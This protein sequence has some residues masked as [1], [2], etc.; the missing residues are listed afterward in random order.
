V[1]GSLARFIILPTEEDYPDENRTGGLRQAPPA[2]IEGLQRLAEGG[3]G[4]SGDIADQ[5]ARA[6]TAVN[7]MTVPMDDAAQARF[8]A[9]G[10]EITIELRAA[11]GTPHTPILARIKENA[12]KVALIVAVG[13]DATQPVIRLDD[14]VWAIDFVRHFARRTIDA[15]ERNVADTQIEAHLKRVRE[16]IRQAGS[17]GISRSQLPRATQWLKVRDREEILFTL[18]ESGDIIPVEKVTGG[19]KAILYRALR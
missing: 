1:D 5:T 17:A 9:L 19:R 3:G 10:D 12:A 4:A 14:A 7:P 16:K 13:R 6:M 2:L 8:D 15:V 18:I 11:T